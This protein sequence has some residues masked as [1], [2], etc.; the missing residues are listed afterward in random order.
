MTKELKGQTIITSKDC[1]KQLPEIPFDV[2]ER[3]ADDILRQAELRQSVLL[4]AGL[5]HLSETALVR[6]VVQNALGQLPELDE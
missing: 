2:S 5:N 4:I 3:S 1:I 6:D